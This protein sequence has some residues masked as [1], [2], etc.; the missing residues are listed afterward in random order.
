[1]DIN[2]QFDESMSDSTATYLPDSGSKSIRQYERLERLDRSHAHSLVRSCHV[3]PDAINASRLLAGHSLWQTLVTSLPLLVADF[4]TLWFLLYGTTA[5]VERICGISTWL[6]TSDSALLAS[7]LLLPIAQLAGLYPAMGMIPAVEFRQLV[8]SVAI[9]LCIFAGIE[10]LQDQAQWPYF[11]AATA[12]TFCLCMPLMPTSRFVARAAARR[13]RWW[14]APVLVYADSASIGGALF[15]RLS[16]SQE[17][18]LRPVAVM[19]DAN[20]Y[21]KAASDL[22]QQGVPAIPV[23]GIL[24]YALRNKATWILVANPKATADESTWSDNDTVNAMLHAIPNR[25]LLSST[26]GF[27]FGMWDRTHTIGTSCGLLLAGSRYCS[28]TLTMKRF[29][30]FSIT[31]L[32]CL[33]ISPL[34]IAIA[35]A[36]RLSSPGPVFYCQKR[37]GRGGHSFR[38]WKFRTM[39]VNADRVLEHYLQT[40]PALL[41]EWRETHKLKRDPRV[42]WI[43]RFLRTTSLDELPQ[44]WNVLRGEMSLVGPRPLVDS[45]NYDATY[46]RDYP[47]EFAVYKSVRPGLT[48]MWQVTC[49]NNGVYEMR[50]YWDMYYV[51]NWSLWLDLYIILRTVRT[52]LFR[53]GSA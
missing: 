23:D 9:A 32:G 36:I 33:L 15:R 50:I 27:D 34:L 38:A 18:G 12:M 30:D 19:L 2:I 42:T 44:L 24:D 25:V 48:G 26:N 37:V 35:I 16:S 52:V 39:V 28:S 53:E 10:I 31:A 11:V 6:V 4:F 1:M 47:R 46:I 29:L 43:G 7:M 45:P 20:K 21:W 49:R 41:R 5:I 40:H 14:G 3:N 8:R 13:C 51:R 22:E 17:R